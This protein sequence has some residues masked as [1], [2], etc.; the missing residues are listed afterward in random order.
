MKTT[1]FALNFEKQLHVL[2]FGAND[3]NN[4]SDN[5]SNFVKAKLYL[6]VSLN[7]IV[8][9]IPLMKCDIT[10]T[11]GQVSEQFNSECL[12]KLTRCSSHVLQWWNRDSTMMKTRYPIAFSPSY[13][14]IIT[15]SPSCHRVSIIVPLCFHQIVQ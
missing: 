3:H 13:H 1:T 5:A 11:E 10:D 12:P 2:N 15:V 7:S 14:G 8:Q 6:P 9:L 4:V